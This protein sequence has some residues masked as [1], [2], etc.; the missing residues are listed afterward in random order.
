MAQQGQER[1][2]TAPPCN[3]GGRT[4]IPPR[5]T[6]KGHRRKGWLPTARP[7]LSRPP[8]AIPRR[9]V[10]RCVIPLVKTDQQR[11]VRAVAGQARQYPR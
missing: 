8:C 6:R 11:A 3:E 1:V 4:P 2:R 9:A 5:M 10:P 7:V